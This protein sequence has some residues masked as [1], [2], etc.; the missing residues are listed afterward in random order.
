M[1]RENSGNLLFLLEF[2]LFLAAFL[3]HQGRE[4]TWRLPRSSAGD[5]GREYTWRLPR[6]AA[7]DQGR[8][9]TWRLPRSS[10]GDQEREWVWS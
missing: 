8:E 3:R 6:S 2:Y 10:A 1:Q 4:Y 5:Q 9:Y 7:G